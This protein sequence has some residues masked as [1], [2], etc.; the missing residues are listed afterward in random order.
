MK[1]LRVVR[2]L[3]RN[4]GLEQKNI[5]LLAKDKCCIFPWMGTVAYRTLERLLNMF[6]RESLAIKSIGG[7]NPYYLIIKLDKTRVNSLYPEIL[8]L[9]EQRITAENLLSDAEA[10]EIQKYDKFIPHALLRKA[11]ASDHLD[12]EELRQ[13][14]GLW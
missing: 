1:R 12:M 13:Q 6:C 10:P 5:L 2:E 9:C 4:S 7:V 3:T 14:V 8:S 11:F